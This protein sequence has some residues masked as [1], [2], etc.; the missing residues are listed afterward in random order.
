[1]MKFVCQIIIISILITETLQAPLESLKGDLRPVDPDEIK[2]TEIEAV[3]VET[4]KPETIQT[5]IVIDPDTTRRTDKYSREI[6]RKAR[7]TRN[8]AIPA[9]LST[10]TRSQIMNHI[11]IDVGRVHEFLSSIRT[12]GRRRIQSF[13]SYG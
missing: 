4:V 6:L 9:I 3:E 1:M 10:R 2:N 11:N 7:K 13:V 12:S 8:I 5:T